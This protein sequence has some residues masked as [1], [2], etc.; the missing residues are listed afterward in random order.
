MKYSRFAVIVVLFVCAFS[1]A[2]VRHYIF[3]MEFLPVV[4]FV[5]FGLGVAIPQLRFFGNFVCSGNRSKK[6]VA[7]TF[8]DGPD[9][10]STPQLL[11]LLRAEKVPAAFF[12]IG[13]NVEQHPGIA[14]RILS[15]G[16][17]VENHSFAHSNYTN[18][19]GR[20]KLKTELLRAQTAIE[21]ATGVAPK[22]FRPPV[23]LSN[24]NTFRVARSLNLQ[25]I[26]WNIRSFDTIT[27]ESSKIVARIRRHLCPGSIIL[28]HDGKI[29]VERLLATVKSLLDELRKLDYQVVR[30]DELLK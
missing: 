8:D 5:V 22:F 16:H 15:E 30:L 19:Y 2:M 24:P 28:L 29:P 23:G 21:K 6:Q 12:C 13:K 11:D 27:S 4:F 17:L 18:F 14:A 9:A 7:L 25:V 10:N 20:E 26:G 1:V 3:L